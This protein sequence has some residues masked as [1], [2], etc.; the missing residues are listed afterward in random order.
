MHVVIVGNGVAGMEAALAIRDREAGWRI[1]VVSEESDHFFS[2]T[3]LMYVLAGQL[4]YRDIEPLE[5]DVYARLRLERVRARAVGLDPAGR[6]L[7][8]ADGSRL[9][10]DRLLIAAGSRPRSGPW[11][12]SDLPGVGHFVT[13][14]DL[15]WLEAEVHAGRGLDAPPR[16][17]AHLPAVP[18]SPYARR[19]VAREQRERAPQ[20]AVVIGGGLVGIEVVET[21]LAAGLAVTFVIREEWFWPI[22]LDADEAA[23]VADALRHHGV[24]VRLQEEVR[25]LEAGPDGTVAAVVTDRGRI[26]ADLV[27]IAI[28]VAPN[29]AWLGD[30]PDL[31]DG[32][33]GILVDEAQRTALPEVWA[34]GD[35]ASVRWANG[36]V[37]P[38]QLWYTARDQGRVAARS[39]LGDPVRYA[40]GTWYNSAK[41]MDLEYTTVGLVNMGV[42][43]E[44]RWFH[45]EEAA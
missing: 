15:E 34:A 8:L 39:L 23:W 25:S 27:V 18:D 24:D 13:L 17:D 21:M 7:L 38:E 42:P 14:Q 20:R 10:Y 36:W 2:R 43:G 30:V 44:Q 37:R 31:R 6:A 41:L 28:G 16:A 40:R 32:G 22:A 4:A 9:A 35:C 45:R 11:P 33:G 26:D 29:T 12:G 3:A 5:R 19:P 1:T